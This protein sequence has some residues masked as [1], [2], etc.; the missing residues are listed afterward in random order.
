MFQMIASVL[1]MVLNDI[2][3]YIQYAK[4]LIIEGVCA[5]ECHLAALPSLVDVQG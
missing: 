3:T 5:A 4:W 2:Q 1:L